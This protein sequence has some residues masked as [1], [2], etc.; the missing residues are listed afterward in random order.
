MIAIALLATIAVASAADVAKHVDQTPAAVAPRRFIP[1]QVTDENKAQ[2]LEV[3]HADECAQLNCGYGTACCTVSNA[4]MWGGAVQ[5]TCCEVDVNEPKRALRGEESEPKRVLTEGADTYCSNITDV[6]VVAGSYSSTACPA[7]FSKLN[8]DLNR[9]AGGDYVYLCYTFAASSYVMEA[10]T[11]V[12]GTSSSI[13]CPYGFSQ[14]GTDLNSG[15]GSVYVFLCI[16][17]SYPEW[18]DD[19]IV[20]ISVQSASSGTDPSLNCPAG[21]NAI[22]HDLNEGVGGD[23]Q[24]MCTESCGTISGVC[25]ASSH[26]CDYYSGGACCANGSSCHYGGCCA[27]PYPVWDGTYCNQL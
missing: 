14:V 25:G 13:D 21:Y 4:N 8:V 15:T 2:P 27:W 23:Y 10:A 5:A 19:S 22:E 26:R 6:T 7:G 1:V 20:A 18:A 12:S 24:L 11:A 9:N 3:R 16:A 17:Y